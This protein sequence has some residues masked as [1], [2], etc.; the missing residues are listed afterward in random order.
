MTYKSPD[1][2]KNSQDKKLVKKF[3]EVQLVYRNR[4]PAAKRPKVNSPQQAY[5]VLLNSWNMDQMELLEECKLLLL[6]RRLRLMSVASISKGGLSGTLVDPKVVFSIALKRR[7][8]SIIL[9]HNHPS[10]NLQPS[11]ADI[12]LTRNFMAAGKLLQIPLE[13]HLIITKEGYHSMISDG[14]LLGN[15]R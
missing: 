10:G 4:T 3:E 7:A 1:H 12:Q 13:D 8:T 9:A 5:D 2:T 6:D 11:H 14:Y 15:D